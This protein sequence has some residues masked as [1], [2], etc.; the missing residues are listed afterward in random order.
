MSVETDL[1][2]G[3]AGLL[4]AAGVGVYK[5]GGVYLATET[6]IVLG[7]LPTSPNRAIGISLYSPVDAIKQ[8]L[9]T[10]RAQ[11]W[12]RGTPNNSLDS[13]DLACAIFDAIHG[14]E[15]VTMGSLWLI[16]CYRL[17]ALTMGIDASKRS[18]RSDNYLV[19]VNTPQT[20]NRPG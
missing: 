18:E 8:N 11:F 2:V 14:I 12:I 13:G 19:Q 1:R 15:G 16:Q 3:L 7:E 9:T 17:S 6:A 20:A 4:E 10:Y 5:P